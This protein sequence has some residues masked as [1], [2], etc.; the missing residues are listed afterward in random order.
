MKVA[1]LSPKGPLYRSRG[2][3][4]RKSL[5]YQP[6]TLT[7]LAALAP[8]EL[9]VRFQLYDEGTGEIPL[10]LDAD[11]VGM[12]VI[13][14]SSNRA[15]ELAAHYRRRGIKVVLGGPHVTLLPDEAQGHADAI[16]TGYA[17]Q[18]WPEL[19]RDFARG[20]LKPRYTQSP[21]LSLA[22]LPFAKRELFAKRD[23]LT[24][25]VFE[26]TRSCAHDCEFCVAPAA[27][28]RRQL[29]KPVE[30]VVADIRQFGARRLI[31]IDLNLISD[32]AY[33]RELFTALVPLKI[34]WFGLSTSLIGRDPDLMELMAR[35]GCSG[36][37]IGFETMGK[38]ALGDIGKKFNDPTLYA[39]L[40]E[41]LH[42]LRISIQ[43]CFVFGNDHDDLDVFERTADFVIDV[44][45]DLPRFAILTPFP[46]TPLHR[47]MEAEGRILTRN[48]E[49]YDGQHV[50]HLPRLMTPQQLQEGHERAW[51]T[52]YSRRAIL[53]RISKARVQIPISI[54]ANLGYRFYAHHL[55]THYNCDWPL[56][57][58]DVA[59]PDVAPARARRAAS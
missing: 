43:G 13:T 30:D 36:L 4:F 22:G 39:K 52:A 24:Q 16:C 42:R 41:D 7:T 8:A 28:G 54:A 12:T 23:Y 15:Y 46:G 37:L 56:I 2:G 21:T 6:L 14:G 32:R 11:L 34:K 3:I 33:A 35:S 51:K 55:H 57:P 27:W 20:A 5:R 59:A 17:D 31:F 45:M 26:A 19:L 29:Q 58:K 9:D 1:L 44:G 48:W 49:L 47:R 38:E 50:V 10:D 25:A 40:V 18:S 53:K